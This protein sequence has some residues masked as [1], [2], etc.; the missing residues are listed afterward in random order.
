MKNAVVIGFSALTLCSCAKRPDAI[1]P[2]AIPVENYTRSTCSDLEFQL[3]SEKDRL[4][5]LSKSQNE[6]ATG[7]AIG[8]FLLG[9]PMSSA[10]GADKEGEVSVQKGKVLAIESAMS[11]NKCRT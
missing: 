10:F 8:V 4:A 9:V 7:D 11:Q 6:A 5:E 3:A 1:A 2:T